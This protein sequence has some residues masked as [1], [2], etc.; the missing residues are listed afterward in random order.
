VWQGRPFVS[1]G[2]VGC[3]L[4]FQRYRLRPALAHVLAD[5]DLIQVVSGM[6]A[7]A[8]GVCGL[9]KPV[10]VFCATRAAVERLSRHRVE[11]GPGEV[12]RR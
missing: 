4:E 7:P 1:V 11:R 3:E 2:A 10:A 6:P 5:C 9:G 8:Y 12:W